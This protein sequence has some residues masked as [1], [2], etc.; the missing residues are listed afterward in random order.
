M[1]SKEQDNK[2][3]IIAVMKRFT[4]QRLPIALSLQ[5]KVDEGEK[6]SD[7]DIKFL[8]TVLSDAQ[9]MKSLIDKNPEYQPL[10]SKAINLYHH[11]TKKALENEN[12]V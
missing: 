1:T 8:E 5:K 9:H 11:I 10:A 2:A 7:W 6:L 12:R 3:T 4:R